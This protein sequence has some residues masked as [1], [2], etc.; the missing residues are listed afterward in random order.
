MKKL[1]LSVAAL[2]LAMMSYGQTQCKELTKDSVQ[3]KNNTKAKNS[4]CYLHNPFYKDA[5]KVPATICNGTTKSG[6]NC[7]NKTK[8][9][10][11]F[12]YLHGTKE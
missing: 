5:V 4:L 9:T 3:C 10:S 7:K 2:S 12:C 8:N 1:T 11:G 6:R